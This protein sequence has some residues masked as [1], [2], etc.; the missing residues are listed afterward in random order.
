MKHWISPLSIMLILLFYLQYRKLVFCYFFEQM[1]W[2][3][4]KNF[5]WKNTSTIK[6][7]VGNTKKEDIDI[8]ALCMTVFKKLDESHNK[9]TPKISEE[10]MIK[11]IQQCSQKQKIDYSLQSGY[12]SFASVLDRIHFLNALVLIQKKRGFF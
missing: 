5:R 10:E 11:Q 1:T 4:H 3:W 6:A 7:V 12:V 8:D 9:V 2:C